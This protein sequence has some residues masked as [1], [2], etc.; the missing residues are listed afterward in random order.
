MFVP[1][2]NGPVVDLKC[3][4]HVSLCNAVAIVLRQV[5]RFKPHA[6]VWWR[7]LL[8]DSN[9]ECSVLTRRM[10]LICSFILRCEWLVRITSIFFYIIKN[11]IFYI[12]LSRT[13]RLLILPYGAFNL[14]LQNVSLILEQK[15]HFPINIEKLVC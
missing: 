15:M 7:H 6:L 9:T 11:I 14:P 2:N 13:H 5:L 3:P 10:C 4:A 12:M 1:L 8:D